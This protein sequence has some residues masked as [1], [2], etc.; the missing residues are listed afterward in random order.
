MRE[1][2]E[3]RGS[4]I[5]VYRSQCTRSP[6]YPT[7]SRGSFTHPQSTFSIY[8]APNLA[9]LHIHHLAAVNEP[10]PILSKVRIR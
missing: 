7:H 8:R 9:V 6:E 2:A 3:C 1:M 5:P 10:L 4:V